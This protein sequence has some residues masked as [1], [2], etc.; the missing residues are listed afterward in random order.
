M[1]GIE[2]SV[3]RNRKGPK[4]YNLTS[5]TLLNLAVKMIKLDTT[6]NLVLIL[7]HHQ[8]KVPQASK[9]CEGAHLNLDSQVSAE[10]NK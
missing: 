7:I 8:D 1:R 2:D 5:S 9:G 3:R 10:S 4:D 6:H